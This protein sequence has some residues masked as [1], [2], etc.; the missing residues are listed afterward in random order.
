MLEILMLHRAAEVAAAPGAHVFPGGGVDGA[1]HE[2]IERGLF[3]GEDH[4]GASRRLD[5]AEGALAYFAAALRELFEEAGL[6]SVR[7]SDGGRFD[8]HAG[9][10]A[11]WRAQLLRGETRWA[12][13]LSTHGLRLDFSGMEYLAHWVTPEGLAHRFDTRFF[14]IRAP[15]AQEA[16]ADGREIDDVVW[17]GAPGALEHARRGEWKL[18]APTERTLRTLATVAGVDEA[19]SVAARETVRR[20][21]PRT[22]IRDGRRELAFPG[23][24][25]Y[26]VE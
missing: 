8:G 5:L 17:T 4:D 25:D 9:Q 18:L 22:I 13:L 14:I 15:E 11:R 24:V 26:G 19:L 10:L 16:S 21:Q 7:R 20:I 2:V 1:D 6:L 23:D 3:L 12:E